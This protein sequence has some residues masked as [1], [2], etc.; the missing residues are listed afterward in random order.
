M[1]VQ[2]IWYYYEKLLSHFSFNIVMYEGFAWLM[3][4]C[5]RLDDW[6][7]WHFY[8]NLS[9]LITINYNSS[10]SVRLAPFLTELRVS[11]LPL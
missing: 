2:E 1:N 10:R 4:T 11:S 7:Y 6:I 5:S 3:M 8:H 9:F